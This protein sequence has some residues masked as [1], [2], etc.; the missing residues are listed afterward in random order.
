MKKNSLFLIKEALVEC[1]CLY[2]MIHIYSFEKLPCLPG[3][4]SKTY[5]NVV[6]LLVLELNV[7]KCCL[8]KKIVCGYMITFQIYFRSCFFV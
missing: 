4:L 3:A 1:R 7:P 8:L 2:L 6:N 5:A